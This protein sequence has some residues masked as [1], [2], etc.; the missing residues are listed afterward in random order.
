MDG[1]PRRRTEVVTVPG[2]PESSM[3]VVVWSSP[4]P[5]P[6][7]VVTANVHGD[8]VV[9]VAAAHELDERLATRLRRGQVVIYP[10]LN[11]RGLM[12]Q[13]RHHPEDGID[14][15][16]VF[17]G[18]P[19][20]TGAARVAHALWADLSSRRPDLVLD[21]HSDSAVSVPYALVDRA[22]SL[23]APRRQELER[24]MS[25]L[26]RATGL[27]VLL[28]YPPE[29]YVR[30]RLDRS[31]AGAVVNGLGQPA[32]TFEVG[33]RRAID[34][35][36][37]RRLG[38]VVERVLGQLGAVDPAPAA[39]PEDTPE[40]ERTWRR[41]PAP[42]VQSAGV[43]VP[44]LRPGERFAAGDVLGVVRAVDGSAREVVRAET[45]GLVVSWAEAAWVEPRAVPGTLAVAEGV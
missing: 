45:A 27:L 12:A 30:F 24:R 44:R 40:P 29:E 2:K 3:P 36:A 7:A 18:E 28:E 9:G 16:R 39:S 19:R 38:D 10:S 35:A 20:G 4:V 1:G 5:G 26:A 43:F 23:P 6:C 33:A 8:E 14:L 31:L 32:L 41:A 22:T 37:V 34:P 15:N 13:S 11:P 21:L 25:A 17:P 42:R